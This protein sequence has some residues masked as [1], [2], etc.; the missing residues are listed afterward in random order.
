MKRTSILSSEDCQERIAHMMMTASIKPRAFS[1]IPKTKT[2]MFAVVCRSLRNA[3]GMLNVMSVFT[4][5]QTKVARRMAHAKSSKMRENSVQRIFLAS[6]GA[7][8]II[9]TAIWA[10][11]SPGSPSGQQI[12]LTMNRTQSC[13]EPTIP[14]T[15][16]SA[17]FAK[18]ALSS[19]DHP[20][21]SLT[22]ASIVTTTY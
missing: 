22:T 20:F 4:V 7:Y 2:D 13:V 14:K 6:I 12:L 17:L 21:A 16:Q 18:P 5:P 9:S 1:L 3:C 8:A 15:L 11:A 19:T 10:D